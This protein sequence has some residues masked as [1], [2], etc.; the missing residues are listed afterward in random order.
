MTFK[1][2]YDKNAP[3]HLKL[4]QEVLVPAIY[5]REILINVNQQ[6]KLSKNKL[7]VYLTNYP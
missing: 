4:T 7:G 2:I 6:S 3:N 1:A 5:D